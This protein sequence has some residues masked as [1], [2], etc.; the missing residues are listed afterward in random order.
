MRGTR[1]RCDARHRRVG[2]IPAYAGNTLSEY[3]VRWGEAGMRASQYFSLLE[4][5]TANGA[6]NLDKVGDFLNEF[7]TS[8]T[9]G[10]MEAGI[11]SFSQGTQDVFRSFQQGGATAQDV[12]NA[13]VGELGSMPD[14]YQAAQ[15]ASETW[16]SLGEDNAMGMIESLANVSDTFGD[17]DGAASEMADTMSQSLGAQATSAFR[18]LMAALEPLGEPL[19]NI[20]KTLAPVV[21][22]FAQWFA[23]LG[24][25]GQT[26][27][28]VI[29]GIV[30][31]IG[32]LL[33]L[34]GTVI[35]VLPMLGGVFAA[36]ASPVG[37]AIAAVVGAIA[38][39]TTLWNTSEEG[40]SPRMRGTLA[41]CEERLVDAGIIPAYA[42]NT[43]G[44]AAPSSRRR[45]HPR[46]CGEHHPQLFVAPL[47]KGSSPRMRGTRWT[48]A[49]W[50][51]MG[52]I[53]PAYAGS[54]RASSPSASFPWDHPRVCG[55]HCFPGFLRRGFLGSSP[56]MRGAPA[57]LL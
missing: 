12:L 19:V 31:A 29:L 7:L 28:V 49:A 35:T 22:G 56:R 1:L 2:I 21:N 18:E 24:G 3:S 6:Y 32:P 48:R 57:H 52:G 43:A 4:A 45:D 13:V 26:A 27:I 33:S 30:A 16:S 54:T 55:K 14:Q 20:A 11:G 46:V 41:I 34:A 40:S 47:V 38:V 50:W 8:L 17:V 25:G 39:I 10:R 15:I 36:I 9:D 53:I 5:G 44:N 51:S 42:G 37:I 23:S